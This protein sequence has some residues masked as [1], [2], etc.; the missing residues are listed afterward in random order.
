MSLLQVVGMVGNPIAGVVYDAAG[1]YP[2][3]LLSLGG[4]ALGVIII[5]SAG[6]LSRLSLT[7]QP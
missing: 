3:Y 1:A 5:V 7:H 4:S 6:F 2:L